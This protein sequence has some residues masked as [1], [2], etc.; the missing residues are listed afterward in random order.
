[1]AEYGPGRGEEDHR[2]ADRC[3]DRF[4]RPIPGEEQIV[5]LDDPP[6]RGDGGPDP[7]PL[8]VLPPGP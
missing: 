5:H 3:V 6:L 2:G 7:G 8:R 4:L 1:M